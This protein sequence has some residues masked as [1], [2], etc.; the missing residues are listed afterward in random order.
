MVV[1]LALMLALVAT[2]LE[3]NEKILEFEK[4]HSKDLVQTIAVPTMIFLYLWP[5]KA[6]LCYYSDYAR[7]PG[8]E[9]CAEKQPV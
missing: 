7:V 2:I 8:A 5:K 6:F 3:E 9:W 1:V 4:R